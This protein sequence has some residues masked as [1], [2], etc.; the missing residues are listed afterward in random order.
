MAKPNETLF[1]FVL[2]SDKTWELVNQSA[3]KVLS[4]FYIITQVSIYHTSE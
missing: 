3:R 1:F 2:K 4:I